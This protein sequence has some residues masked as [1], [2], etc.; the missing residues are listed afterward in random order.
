MSINSATPQ[1]TWDHI[2][3]SGCLLYDWWESV[4]YRG[5]D[6]AGAVSPGWEADVTA[7]TEADSDPSSTVTVTVTHAD[8]MAAARKVMKARPRYAS[9]VLG[10]ECR[11]LVFDVDEADFDA[12]CAD[13]L[14]QVIVLGEIVYG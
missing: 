1:Q 11:N 8:I 12:P 5:V 14:L 4:T 9:D 13:E 2:F 6:E 3:G 10:R 7:L